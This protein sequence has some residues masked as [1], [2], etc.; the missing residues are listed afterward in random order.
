M[1]FTRPDLP[2]TGYER[3]ID[4]HGRSGNM[5]GE[6]GAD[7]GPCFVGECRIAFATSISFFS[8]QPHIKIIRPGG[9]RCAADGSGSGKS[10]AGMVT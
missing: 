5:A 4:P 7:R 1:T 6:G 2:D 10:G 3:S 8:Q 9:F